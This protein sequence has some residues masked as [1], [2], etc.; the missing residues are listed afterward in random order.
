MPMKKYKAEQIGR[1]F[2][3]IRV[4]HAGEMTTRRP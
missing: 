1:F 4:R 3:L 2:C